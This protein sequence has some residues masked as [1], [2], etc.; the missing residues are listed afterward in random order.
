MCYGRIL[1]VELE[2]RE[3]SRSTECAGALLPAINAMA[4]K[5]V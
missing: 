4:M 1:L 3:N 2:E 5:Q